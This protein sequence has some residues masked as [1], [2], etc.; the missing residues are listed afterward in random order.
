[1][2]SATVDFSLNRSRAMLAAKFRRNGSTI[3]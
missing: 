1:M 2:F 3:Q